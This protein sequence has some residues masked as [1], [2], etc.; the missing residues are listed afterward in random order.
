MPSRHTH[1]HTSNDGGDDDNGSDDSDCNGGG[2]DDSDDIDASMAQVMAQLHLADTE[3]ED[4]D[5]DATRTHN[6]A[7]HREE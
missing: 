1:F 5:E 2:G 6:I 4:G 7:W 3:V